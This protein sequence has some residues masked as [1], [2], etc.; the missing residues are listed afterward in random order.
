VTGAPIDAGALFPPLRTSAPAKIN[1]G[2]F[3]GP[4][5]ADGRHELAT[6]MQPISLADEVVLEDAPDASADLV[7]CPGVAGEN[8]AARALALFRSATGWE[9]GPVR[10]RIAKRIPV[11][12]GL[13][14]GSADAGAAL[15]LAHAASRVGDDAL[16][17]EIAAELGADVPSQVQPA[18]VLATGAGERLHSL[19]EPIRTVGVLVAPQAEGL[20]TA[21]VYAQADAL[22]SVRTAAQLRDLRERLSRALALGSPLPDS[23]LLLNDL[24]QACRA[25]SPAADR[26]LAQVERAGAEHALVSGSGP[27]VLGL[28]ARANGAE[29]ARRAA[30]ALADRVPAPIAAHTVGAD[31]AAVAP[32]GT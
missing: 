3:V 4:T 2:L 21:E 8:L 22:G 12:A 32:V 18:R 15:R 6:V 31:F 26:A 13:A 7:L 16:L 9:H 23:E 25:L 11:A 30:A 29:R 20:S 5:R 28:F 1:L 19:P 17:L 24:Q 14:G 10:L 27:T